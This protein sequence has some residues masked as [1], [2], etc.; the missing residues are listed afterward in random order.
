M[1][2][3]VILADAVLAETHSEIFELWG[4]EISA[5]SS[6]SYRHVT[7]IFGVIRELSGS[8]EEVPHT[9]KT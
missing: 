2:R 6:A 1:Y 7:R 4:E 5:A 8:V 3:N 9:Q